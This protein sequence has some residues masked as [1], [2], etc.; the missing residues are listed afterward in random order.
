MAAYTPWL[1]LQRRRKM[2]WYTRLPYCAAVSSLCCPIL[3]QI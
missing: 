2:E 1:G 3:S